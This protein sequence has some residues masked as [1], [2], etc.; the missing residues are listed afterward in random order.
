M[1]KLQLEAKVKRLQKRLQ[2]ARV[3]LKV[4]KTEVYWREGGKER[5]AL[6]CGM[7]KWLRGHSK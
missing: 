5:W 2:S 4:A 1:T 7:S 3:L 6:F